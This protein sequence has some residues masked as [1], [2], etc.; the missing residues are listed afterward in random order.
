MKED[1]GSCP[2]VISRSIEGKGLLI[3]RRGEW[4]IARY[5]RGQKNRAKKSFR[6]V[7]RLNPGTVVLF[8]LLRES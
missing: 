3:K 5:V 2:H 6:L 1:K 4:E 8:K 7:I